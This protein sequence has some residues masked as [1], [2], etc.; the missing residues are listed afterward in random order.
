MPNLEFFHSRRLPSLLEQDHACERYRVPAL[1]V[2]HLLLEPGDQVSIVD[3]EGLQEVQMQAFDTDN[4]S[5]NEFL[6]SPAQASTAELNQWLYAN[7][8]FSFDNQDGIRLAGADSAPNQR[9]SFV[10][11]Q[12]LSVYIATPGLDMSTDQPNP[13]SDI[14]VEVTRAQSSNHSTD[15]PAP[16][17]T[18]LREIRVNACTA[19]GFKVKAGEYIQI[20]DVSGQQCSDFV[21]YDA[22]ALAEGKEVS[23]CPTTTRSLMAQSYPQPGLYNKYYN[24]NMD[25][26]VELIQD[27]I[28]RHDTFNLACNAKYYDDSGYP[29]HVNCSDNLN[30]ALADYAISAK[31]SWPAINYFFNTGFNTF[32]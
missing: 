24:A 12:A 6:N 27:T 11:S 21:A 20:I 14:V 8:V 26:M 1:S 5:A 23:I 32:I 2:T 9:T 28:G 29:G 31:K 22:A 19:E 17:A 25:T 13:P 7:T 3:P 18:P 16:L 4:Q 15:L 30:A 10:T